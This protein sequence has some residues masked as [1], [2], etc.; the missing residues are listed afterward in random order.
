M[1]DK[2]RNIIKQD[3]PYYDSTTCLPL[4]MKPQTTGSEQAPQITP[5]ELP[6]Q[7]RI[8]PQEPLCQAPE[9]PFDS[10][11]ER[12]PRLKQPPA[13][14]NND[15]IVSI[16]RDGNC[17]FR[18]ISYSLYETQSKHA[19]KLS[20]KLYVGESHTSIV[21]NNCSIFQFLYE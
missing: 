14:A 3:I 17:Q 19:G 10:P 6:E 18:A 13:Q 16:E 20:F 11:P 21:S 8:P 9:R 2:K 15:R 12:P 7:H 1:I 5:I 4:I